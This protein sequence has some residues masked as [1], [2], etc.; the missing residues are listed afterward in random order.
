[1]TFKSTK[2]ASWGGTTDIS[3][4]GENKT[5]GYVL[6]DFFTYCCINCMHILPALHDLEQDASLTVLGVHSGK[7]KNEKDA[8]NILK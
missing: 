8:T 6:L 4:S 3:L 2:I 1:M 5:G 7:F